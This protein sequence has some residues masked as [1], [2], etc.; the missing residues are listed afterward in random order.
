MYMSQGALFFASYEF[1]KSLF[2]LE[3]PHTS[4]QRTWHKQKSKDGIRL[5]Q[6][7]FVSSSSSGSDPVS[8]S[9][10]SSLRS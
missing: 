7:A 9:S 10:S 4:T 2:S 8:S 3:V 5:E 6:S 1:F